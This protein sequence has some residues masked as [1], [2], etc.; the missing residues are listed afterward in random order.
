[1]WTSHR[2]YRYRFDEFYCS[3]GYGS[4]EYV[5]SADTLGNMGRHKSEFNADTS[6]GNYF[7]P[8]GPK[9]VITDHHFFE[10]QK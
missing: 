10:V 9:L 4:G 3:P 7:A 8:L 2:V 5:F 1:M 6:E